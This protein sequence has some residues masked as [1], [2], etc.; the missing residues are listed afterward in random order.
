MKHG[1]TNTDKYNTNTEQYGNHTRNTDKQYKAYWKYL[2][3]QNIL[4]TCYNNNK[5]TEQ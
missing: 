5:H 2:K 3:I 1:T 4:K